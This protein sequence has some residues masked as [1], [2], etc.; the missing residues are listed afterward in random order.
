MKKLTREQ[1]TRY[2]RDGYICPV[3]AFSADRAAAWHEQLQA[4][5]RAEGQKMTRGHNFKPHLLF[6]WVDE[7]VRAPEVLDAVEDLIGPDIRVFHLSVWPKDP[8]SGTYVS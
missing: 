8:G 3:D 4:F 2:E 5:E 6:P 1:I 7:I